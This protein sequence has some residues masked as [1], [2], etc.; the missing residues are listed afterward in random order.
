[1]AKARGP[2]VEVCDLG[3]NNTPAAADR[4]C[5]RP[6]IYIRLVLKRTLY[7]APLAS[8][9]TS[10][11]VVDDLD[12]SG[13]PKVKYKVR[14][15]TIILQISHNQLFICYFHIILYDS[16]IITHILMTGT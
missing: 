6:A 14:C 3:T 5:E 11:V 8:Y 9:S 2:I 10:K 7:L 12:L 13:S 15:Y 1:M 4:S 16:D